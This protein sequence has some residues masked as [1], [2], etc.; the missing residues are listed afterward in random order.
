MNILFCA[1]YLYPALAGGSKGMIPLLSALSSSGHRVIS[2]NGGP[3]FNMQKELI[4]NQDNFN[5]CICNDPI[6]KAKEIIPEFQPDLIIS[7]AWGSPEAISLAHENNIKSLL[8]IIDLYQFDEDN[9]GGVDCKKNIEIYKNVSVAVSLSEFLQKKA[10]TLIGIPSEIIYPVIFP[11]EYTVK[12]PIE[13]SY[14][15]MASALQ[16]K[17]I[18]TVL[19]M[20]DQLPFPI[21][22]CGEIDKDYIDKVESNPKIKYIGRI[23]D[24]RQLYKYSICHLVLS[25]IAEPF[26]RI[27]VEANLNGIPVVALN[28]G[29]SPEIIGQAGGVIINSPKELPEAV[30]KAV[31]IPEKECINNAKRFHPDVQINKFIKLINNLENQ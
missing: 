16:V 30:K 4:F 17:G 7:Q 28:S 12:E 9:R 23:E 27:S 15:T 3:K 22:I 19:E 31:K 29:G 14:I 18:D 26:G 10:Q 25:T 2:I 20:A 8:F 11:D 1:T 24:M 6:K 5:A 21:L 13:K